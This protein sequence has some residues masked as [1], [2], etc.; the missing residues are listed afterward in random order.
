MYHFTTLATLDVCA[1][2][3]YVTVLF[4]TNTVLSVW[5]VRMLQSQG[6]N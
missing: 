3:E 4:V 1:D 6:L 5:S 2:V